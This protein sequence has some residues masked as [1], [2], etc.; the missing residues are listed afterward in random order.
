MSE[1]IITAQNT[2]RKLVETRFSEL[3]LRKNLAGQYNH[4]DIMTLKK[5]IKDVLRSQWNTLTPGKGVK[6]LLKKA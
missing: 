1:V 5:G 6:M 2:V 4:D 3:E